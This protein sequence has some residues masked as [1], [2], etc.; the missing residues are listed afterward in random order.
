MSRLSR[1]LSPLVPR[2]AWHI[3]GRWCEARGAR[4][5][6]RALYGTV[7]ELEAAARYDALQRARAGKYF[8]K[9]GGR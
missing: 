1:A 5:L 4:A 9:R 3:L 6:R 8:S 2:A 7:A